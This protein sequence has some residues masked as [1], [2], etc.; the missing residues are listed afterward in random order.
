MNFYANIIESKQ[1]VLGDPYF[2]QTKEEIKKW[3]KGMKITKC[4]INSDLTVDVNG[5]VDL[6][7]TELTKIPVKFNRVSGWFL[8]NSN[9]LESLKGCPDYVGTEFNCT[10]NGLTSLEYCPKEVGG[11]FFCTFNN[12]TSLKY[13]PKKVGKGFYCFS[14]ELTSL[15]HCPA[16]INKSFYC[17]DNKLTSFEYFPIVKEETNINGNPIETLKGLENISAYLLTDLIRDYPDLDWRD[18]EWNKVKNIDEIVTELYEFIKYDKNAKGSKK[19]LER[20]EELQ[21]Y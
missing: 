12:L 21:L 19:V 4:V 1:P 8:C 3:L 18:I 7:V 10:G 15:E 13:C 11:S 2:L 20:I 17:N 9:K 6:V 14:N 5:R 16:V